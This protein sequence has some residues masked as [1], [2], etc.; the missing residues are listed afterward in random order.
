MLFY[1]MD[2]FIDCARVTKHLLISLRGIGSFYLTN[3]LLPVISKKM[4]FEKAQKIFNEL[5]NEYNVKFYDSCCNVLHV[6][7]RPCEYAN[8]LK[9]LYT[10]KKRS[11]FMQERHFNDAIKFGLNFVRY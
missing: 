11:Y 6:L 8:L 5:K 10:M 4:K 2:T 1:N 9:K 3:T 7:I